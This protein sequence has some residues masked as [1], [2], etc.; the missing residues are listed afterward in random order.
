VG[1]Y[2]ARAAVRADHGPR[3]HRL[4]ALQDDGDR[5]PVRYGRAVLF[6]PLHGDAGAQLGARLLRVLHELLVELGP[7][8]QPE[9]HLPGAAGAAE[10][11][12]VRE[13]HRVHPVLERKLEAG[14]E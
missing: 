13:R 1:P 9:Q 11:A 6:H 5:A 3:E 4:A 2:A 10:A 14:R 12:V 7:V 8:D